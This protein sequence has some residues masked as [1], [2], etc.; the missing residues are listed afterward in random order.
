[1][2]VQF[3]ALFN[4]KNLKFLLIV[5]IVKPSDRVVSFVLEAA[6]APVR[7]TEER[8]LTLVV[9]VHCNNRSLSTGLDQQHTT[10]REEKKTH[11]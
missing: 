11:I 9:P 7:N 2:F 8:L 6:A 5:T 4:Q 10:L 1:M 3:F